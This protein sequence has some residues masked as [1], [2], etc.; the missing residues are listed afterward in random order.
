MAPVP[1]FIRLCE[2]LLR[3]TRE[4]LNYCKP[5]KFTLKTVDTFFTEVIKG[6]RKLFVSDIGKNNHEL[7]QI[8]SEGHAKYGYATYDMKRDILTNK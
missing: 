7:R 1:V 5:S 6:N 4:L 2:Y 3:E 8:D